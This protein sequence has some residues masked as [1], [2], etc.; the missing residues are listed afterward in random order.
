[1]L[2]KLPAPRA[3]KKHGAITMKG[4]LQSGCSVTHLRGFFQLVVPDL[5][6]RISRVVGV[7]RTGSGGGV[8][9]VVRDPV[10]GVGL[11]KCLVGGGEGGLRV[12]FLACCV[13]P[14]FL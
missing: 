8:G 6:V 3:S 1:M 13:K 4:G 9:H 10:G 14:S 2:Q 12:V 11:N 5:G 7:V